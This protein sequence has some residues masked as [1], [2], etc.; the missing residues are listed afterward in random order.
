MDD[1]PTCGKGLAEHSALPAALGAL[2]A[3]L[4]ENLELH[5][6]TLDL[7]DP[8]SRK[9]LDAYVGL[10][11]EHREIAERLKA[12]ASRMASYRDLP[13]GRHD[14]R[15]LADPR[16]LGAFETFVQREEE[17]LSLLLGAHERDEQML[18]AARGSEV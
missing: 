4:A 14:G 8:S 15:A 9:E 16:L 5:Q 10:A 3:A 18:R 17:L 2:I 11:K 12:V 7:T 6:G 1:Q 13:M